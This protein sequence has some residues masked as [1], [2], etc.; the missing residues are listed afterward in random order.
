M[1]PDLSVLGQSAYVIIFVGA[2]QVHKHIALQPLP[3]LNPRRELDQPLV[4][5]SQDVSKP[6]KSPASYGQ[7]QVEASSVN[8][9]LFVRCLA[10]LL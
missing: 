4:R 8:T 6:F 10:S 9:G 3:V 5:H 2:R 1:S 7:H